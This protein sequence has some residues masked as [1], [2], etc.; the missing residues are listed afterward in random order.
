MAALAALAHAP[1]AGACAQ[2]RTPECIRCHGHAPISDDECDRCVPAMRAA[3]LTLTSAQ[4]GELRTWYSNHSVLMLGSSVMRNKIAYLHSIG[5]RSACAHGNGV[6][7]FLSTSHSDAVLKLC[8]STRF[9]APL[10][11]RR[12]WDVV[13]W[14]M[15]PLHWMHLHPERPRA[16]GMRCRPGEPPAGI[17]NGTRRAGIEGAGSSVRTRDLCSFRA[18]YESMRAC[19]ARINVNLGESVRVVALANHVCAGSYTGAYARASAQW[20]RQ[21]EDPL[22]T[23]QMNEEGVHA[24]HVAER[25]VAREYGHH[26]QDSYTRGVCACTHSGDGRHYDPLDPTFLYRA[27]TRLAYMLKHKRSWGR[28]FGLRFGSLLSAVAGR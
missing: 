7:G 13:L 16:V 15:Q 11:H 26:L 22:Y 28:R 6:C 17:G 1:I 20:A 14:N 8:S 2:S 21:A 25:E 19:A 18:L 9:P 27:S 12:D 5:V 24:A 23:M 10:T 3:N 4:L